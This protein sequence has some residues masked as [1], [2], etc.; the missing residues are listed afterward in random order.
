LLGFGHRSQDLVQLK[1]AEPSKKTQTQASEPS[2]G[3]V[4]HGM[5]DS[6]NKGDSEGKQVF[7]INHIIYINS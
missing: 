7:S 3:G 4:T 5:Y 2:P 1:D 6:F